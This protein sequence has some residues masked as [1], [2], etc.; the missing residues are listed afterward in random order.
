MPELSTSHGANAISQC[1]NS[2][3]QLL[4]KTRAQYD[5][6]K[7][8]NPNI[9][10]IVEET[11]SRLKERFIELIELVLIENRQL[12]GGMDREARRGKSAV[13]WQYGP[14]T[15]YFLKN[16]LL[17]TVVSFTAGNEMP[18]D[19]VDEVAYLIASLAHDLP[20][21]FLVNEAI[22]R[23]TALFFETLIAKPSKYSVVLCE[24]MVSRIEECPPLWALFAAENDNSLAQLIALL[25]PI[26]EAFDHMAV[27]F[28]RLCN[29]D[30]VDVEP[31]LL[32][33]VIE[34]C[35]ARWIQDVEVVVKSAWTDESI[36]AFI[37]SA[38]TL[39]GIVEALSDE[40][41]CSLAQ[42]VKDQL[43]R[44]HLKPAL[45]QLKFHDNSVVQSINLLS[46]LCKRVDSVE[47][48]LPIAQCFK[49][50]FFTELVDDTDCINLPRML[51]TDGETGVS[52]A[53]VSLIHAMLDNGSRKLLTVFQRP[54]PVP[55]S[56]P[57][58]TIAQHQ[59]MCSDLMALIDR[60]PEP[61]RDKNMDNM[62]LLY[63]SHLIMAERD[64]PEREEE[65]NVV[66]EETSVLSSLLIKILD[67]FTLEYWGRD[68][69]HNLRLCRLLLALVS[70]CDMGFVGERLL[71][72]DEI[73]SL[74]VLGGRLMDATDKAPLQEHISRAETLRSVARFR[75][76]LFEQV[77]K[78]LLEKTDMFAQDG[79]LEAS[80][81]EMEAKTVGALSGNVLLFSCF[82]LR[83]LAIVQVQGTRQ[84]K[85]I[86][87][88]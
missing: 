43:V 86:I 1:W 70:R 59:A 35:M 39:D 61:I 15:E 44:P 84:Y 53:V 55:I 56:P 33:D 11:S 17:G 20:A 28:R 72:S 48:C 45:R 38:E 18:R 3:Y 32:E 52:F 67:S 37:G 12:N 62:S 42:A 8:Q 51:F 31:V 79:F 73:F 85:T 46:Q 76:T 40:G 16:D 58:L 30:G 41:K 75:A 26:P 4:S 49:N 25:F 9:T 57:C 65:L 68:P 27:L 19:L 5:D 77:H 83:L 23:P 80:L 6:L 63:R 24:K 29:V 22:L 2:I 10:I 66:D 74:L 36:A 60:L 50:Y 88:S 69:E 64:I 71:G 14:T 78:G 54:Q 21:S 13:E 87:Y 7:A 47:L 34:S 82:Y 81:A